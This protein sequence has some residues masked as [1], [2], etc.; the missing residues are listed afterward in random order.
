MDDWATKTIGPRADSNTSGDIEARAGGTIST[1]RVDRDWAGM[2]MDGAV[3][4]IRVGRGS[5]IGTC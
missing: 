2:V 1:T 4:T 5:T 3:T